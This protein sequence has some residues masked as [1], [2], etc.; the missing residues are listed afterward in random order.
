ML[1]TEFPVHCNFVQWRACACV[2]V[3]LY[4]KHNL[5]AAEKP[6][7]HSNFKIAIASMRYFI[8]HTQQHCG[9]YSKINTSAI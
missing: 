1:K 4:L 9:H 5:T 7:K 3:R 8:K 6:L 2:C